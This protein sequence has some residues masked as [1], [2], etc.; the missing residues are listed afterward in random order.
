MKKLLNF[1]TVIGF[2]ILILFAINLILNE[3]VNSV[4]SFQ[5]YIEQFG[6]F[7]P[8]VLLV[9]QA[10]QVVIPI[11]P[12]QIG[13]A[14]GGIAF[15]VGLGFWCNYIGVCIGSIMAYFLARRYGTK[16]ILAFFSQK[17]YNKWQRK[18]ARSNSY[19]WL[20]FVATI[21]PM[22][23]DDLLCYFSGLM[24][25]D[26]KKFIWI[27]IIGKPWCILGYVFLFSLIN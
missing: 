23:P 18:I 4:E 2:I 16:I 11:F 3:G 25:M 21:L 13:C 24:K 10:L 20:L 5:A 6:I 8:I 7:A 14:V 27:I 22:F 1:F 17:Q 12:G 15:G 9:F 19:D 26:K